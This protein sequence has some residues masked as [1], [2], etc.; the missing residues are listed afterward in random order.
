MVTV[1]SGKGKEKE[2]G[3][4][5]AKVGGA[6]RC[7]RCI[8]DDVACIIRME[9]I[10][11]WK[12]DDEAGKTF[13]R[14]PTDTICRYCSEKRKPC[15]LPATEKMRQRMTA[16]GVVKRSGGGGGGSVASVASGSKRTLPD[17]KVEL[18]APRKRA[19]ETAATP[20][21]ERWERLFAVLARIAESTRRQAVAAEGTAET[22]E[23]IRRFMEERV[24]RRERDA[25][26]AE[27]AQPVPIEDE[28]SEGTG[29]DSGRDGDEEDEEEEDAEGEQEEG[30][31]T[32]S[33]GRKGKEVE[34]VEMVAVSK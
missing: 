5:W 20:E 2:L 14:A 23:R 4:G 25:E 1:R 17:A 33:S 18:A 24:E 32:E 34:D 7:K 16:G 28:R 15:E 27:E 8:A 29:T 13:R 12:E 6:G 11:K 30:E 3:S 19:R 21:E 22:M 10:E 9:A 31:I 26:V